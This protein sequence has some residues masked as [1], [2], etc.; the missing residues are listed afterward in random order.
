[1]ALPSVTYTEVSSENMR[2]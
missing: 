1:M 2:R